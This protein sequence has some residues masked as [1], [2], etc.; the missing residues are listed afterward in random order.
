MIRR[1]FLFSLRIGAL[2]SCAVF[3]QTPGTAIRS[4]CIVYRDAR[5]L[6]Q[7][8]KTQEVIELNGSGLAANVGNRVEISG[9]V[10][11]AK[12][13]VSIATTVLT[14]TS[15]APK[16][17]GGCLTVAVSLGAKADVPETA[18]P[19]ADKKGNNPKPK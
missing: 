14:V 8:Q 10:S 11:N 18:A 17:F 7:D 9:T 5:F 12:P 2:L 13:A 4:G 3:A 6:L 16:A 15:V 1:S 19:T